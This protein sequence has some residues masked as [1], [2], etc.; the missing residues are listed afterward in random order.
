MRR[1]AAA[2]TL[3][4]QLWLGWAAVG[5][6]PRGSVTPPEA[7]HLEARTPSVAIDGLT[8][9]AG[10]SGSLLARLTFDTGRLAPRDS[11]AGGRS[12]ARLAVAA[13]AH[14]VLVERS[15]PQRKPSPLLGYRSRGRGS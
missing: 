1:L 8:G 11:L 3:L 10:G 15:D 6:G 4:S 7:G 5:E 9:T 13:H 14:R 2:L 12:A